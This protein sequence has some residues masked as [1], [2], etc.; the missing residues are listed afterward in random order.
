MAGQT[1]RE[2]VGETRSAAGIGAGEIQQLLIFSLK[3]EE[4]CTPIASV[5]EV[6]R[7]PGITRVPR[8]PGFL[9]G[10][11]NLRGKIIPVIDLRERF[12]L[13]QVTFGTT[14]RIIVIQVVNQLVGYVVDSVSEVIRLETEAIGPVPAS[15]SSQVEAHYLTGIAKIK[16]RL[17]ILINFEKILTGLE[18]E[19]IQGFQAAPQQ[20]I[21]VEQ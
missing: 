1:T 4:Y 15:I 10:V 12:G 3:N 2:K 21:K 19:T 16:D 5:Q 18:Q 6:I 11:I 9:K 17:L 13:P 14:T 20:D 7:I 8:M